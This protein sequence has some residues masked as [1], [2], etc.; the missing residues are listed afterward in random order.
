MDAQEPGIETS[1]SR[2][3]APSLHSATTLAAAVATCNPA[4]TVVGT[5]PV[6]RLAKPMARSMLKVHHKAMTDLIF[7]SITIGFFALA[8]LYVRACERL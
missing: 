7:V 5:K 6:Q 4:P 3:I 2:L 1:Q 8:W